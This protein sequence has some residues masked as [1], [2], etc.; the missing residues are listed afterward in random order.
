MIS[1][2]ISAYDKPTVAREVI[3]DLIEAGCDEDDV[4][5]LDSASDDADED[6]IMEDLLDRG[7]SLEDAELYAEAARLGKTLVA[8][9][10]D[11]V[12]AP[13]VEAIMERH[14]A[15]SLEDLEALRDE[16]LDEDED[17]DEDLDLAE[18]EED[19]D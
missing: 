4:E 19:K 10:A 3:V 18:D 17:E 12:V 6:E 15:I 5:I 7:L 13:D 2:I 16:G 9:R 14:G 8:A 1:S 11:D